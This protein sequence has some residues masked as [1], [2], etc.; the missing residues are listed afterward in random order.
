MTEPSTTGDVLKRLGMTKA[1][2]WQLLAKYPHLKPAKQFYRP[3]NKSYAWTEAE[4]QAVE[5]HRAT[6]PPGRRAH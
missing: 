3:G 4:I 6:H 1:G 5:R 2:L